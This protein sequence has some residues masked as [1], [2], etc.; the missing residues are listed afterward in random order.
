MIK[1]ATILK[2]WAE[3]TDNK[4]EEKLRKI[5]Q[6]QS[7][8]LEKQRKLAIIGEMASMLSHDLRNPLSVIQVSVENLI[9]LYGTDDNKQKQFDKIKYSIDRIIQQVDN[10]LDYVK[11]RPR[12]FTK[13]KTSKIIF[14]SINSLAIPD[15][16]K[17]KI[18]QNDFD[19]SCDMRLLSVV[20]SNLMLNSIQA[21]NKEG[22]ISIRVR[23]NSYSV[24][25]EIEDSGPGIPEKYLSRIF[26]PLFTTKQTGTGLGLVSVKTIIDAHRGKI[27][28]TNS[29]TKFKITM[30]KNPIIS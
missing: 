15:T 29:P 13:T 21:M 9:L 8:E 10:V 11:D 28:V 25:I 20:I 27:S 18:P 7:E 24:I 6:I 22:I 17:V 23:E 16:V 2:D 4:S 30:P 5:I 14:D 26:E 1:N 12:E 3:T 19:I